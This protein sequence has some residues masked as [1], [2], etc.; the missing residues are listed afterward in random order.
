MSEADESESRFRYDEQLL[1][2][3]RE[4][5]ARFYLS[6]QGLPRTSPLFHPGDARPCTAEGRDSIVIGS[7]GDDDFGSYCVDVDTGEVVI[8]SLRGGDGIGH[9][10]ASPEAFARCISEFSRRCPYGD[11]ETSQEEFE[12]ISAELGRALS[13]ID[14]SVFDED[15][16]FW[17]NLLHDVAIGDYAEV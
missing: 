8:L 13:A 12:L 2:L 1:S 11:G 9:V 17:C 4:P 6:S 15:P 3:I 7:D 16:G 5:A 14:D 10:N